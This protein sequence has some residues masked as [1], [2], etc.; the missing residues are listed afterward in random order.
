MS[1]GDLGKAYVGIL[2]KKFG[3]GGLIFILGLLI[4]LGIGYLVF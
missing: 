4:G 2:L 3:S 1:T